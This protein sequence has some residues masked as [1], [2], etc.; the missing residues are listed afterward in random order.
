[1]K[2]GSRMSIEAKQKIS[3][4]MRGERNPFFGR[5]HTK[6][7]KDKLATRIVSQE[8]RDKISAARKGKS[9]SSEHRA[10]IAKAGMGKRPT[11]E[12]RI[13]LSESKKGT[14]HPRWCG[15]RRKTKSGYIEIRIPQ[16]PNAGAFGFVLE[17]RL[18]MENNLG[19]YLSKEEKVHHI[20]GV[21]D[22]NR[23]ENLKLISQSE[24]AK[25]HGL[26]GNRHGK[27]SN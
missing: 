11:E 20:N 14:N 13:K 10:A 2:K 8:T 19:R 23:I 9:L 3:K 25:I 15:N 1:M 12:T 22:D 21:R 18:V 7:T 4:A 24:H 26:G 27:A 16:H 6:E 17:H 5:S